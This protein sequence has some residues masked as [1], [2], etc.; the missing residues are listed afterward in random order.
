VIL[1]ECGEIV[2]A[3]GTFRDF[4]ETKANPSTPTIGH[5]Q[6]GLI[7]NFID[8]EMPKRYSSRK[9]LKTIAI[10]LAKKEKMNEEEIGKFLLEV[11]RLKSFGNRSDGQILVAALKNVVVKRSEY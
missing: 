2:D 10:K 3:G 6:C 5:S 8:G 7:F 9:V 4:I 11:D 1:C